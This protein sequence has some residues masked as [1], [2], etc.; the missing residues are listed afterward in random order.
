MPPGLPQHLPD[1]ALRVLKDAGD[2]IRTQASN[3]GENKR[4]P[5]LLREPRQSRAHCLFIGSIRELL[6]SG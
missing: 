1:P 5:L 4:H 3:A 6:A 2:P